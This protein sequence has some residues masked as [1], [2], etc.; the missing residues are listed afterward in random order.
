MDS[1][2]NPKGMGPSS[3]QPGF[4]NFS[5]VPLAMPMQLYKSKVHLQKFLKMEPKVLGTIQIIIGLVNFSLGMVLILIPMDPYMHESFLFHSGYIFWGTAFFIISG[6]LSIA[7]EKKTTNTL[8]QSS[9]AMNIL[10]SVVA[11]LGIIF[12]SLNL[13]WFDHAHYFCYRNNQNEVCIFGHFLLVGINIILLILTILEFILSLV[14]S[15]FGCKTSCCNQSGVTVFMPSP[16]SVPENPTAE[17][18]KG[19]T[20]Q[21]P[22]ADPSAL[23]GSHPDSFV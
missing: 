23:P 9:L 6:S 8:I 13:I 16:P 15:G 20:V 3:S 17:A 2:E 21:S 18:C 14:V 12:F 10:S 11:G 1:Q 5:Q 22:A 7:A 4:L 19:G